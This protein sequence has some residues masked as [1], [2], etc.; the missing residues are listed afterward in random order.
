MA[1]HDQPY[2]R[3]EMLGRPI[4]HWRTLKG[5]ADG[6]PARLRARFGQFRPPVDPYT[7]AH[8]IGVEL[9]HVVDRQWS[10]AIKFEGDRAVVWLNDHDPRRRKRFTLAHELGHLMLHGSG[11]RGMFRDLTFSGSHE[12]REANEWAAAL[13]M[14]AKMVY[15]YASLVNYDLRRLAHIFDVSEDA[16]SLRIEILARRRIRRIRELSGGE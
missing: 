6:T 11:G 15:K 1:D 7:I 16:M 5:T 4:Q 2:A 13:I 3:P 10:G 14:P 12:E 8:G 9:R